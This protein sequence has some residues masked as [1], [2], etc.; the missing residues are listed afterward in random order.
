MSLSHAEVCTSL[1][2]TVIVMLAPVNASRTAIFML[3]PTQVTLL[4]HTMT[5][6]TFE[7]VQAS[8][9]E[10]TSTSA[11]VSEDSPLSLAL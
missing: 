6:H 1:A 7:M 5:A 9:L 11:S 10:V 3:V 2:E 4:P 8:D